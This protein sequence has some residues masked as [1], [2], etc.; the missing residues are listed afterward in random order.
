MPV[1]TFRTTLSVFS[2]VGCSWPRGATP[3]YART[4]SHTST[5]WTH[6]WL[7]RQMWIA[8]LIHQT[9][10]KLTETSETRLLK[11]LCLPLMLLNLTC[12]DR[13]RDSECQ[14][15]TEFIHLKQQRKQSAV[16]YNCRCSHL[17]QTSHTTQRKSCE[18]CAPARTQR[19]TTCHKS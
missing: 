5:L 14:S 10:T 12:A 3:L 7:P 18:V 11:C 4:T 15:K 6:S 17:N 13:D 9:S 8:L 19:Q 1:V 16:S 2:I